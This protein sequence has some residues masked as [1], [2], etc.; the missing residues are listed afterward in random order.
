MPVRIKLK[1]F[2]EKAIG[3][4]YIP[5]TDANGDQRYLF[6]ADAIADD[7]DIELFPQYAGALTANDEIVL[8]RDATG[9]EVRVTIQQ[10]LDLVTLG[11]VDTI[12]NADGSIVGNRIVTGDT[13]SDLAFVDF[14]Q[15]LFDLNELVVTNVA[16]APAVDD[17]LV[18]EPGGTIRKRNIS[19]LPSGGGGAAGIFYALTPFAN[20][21]AVMVHASGTGVTAQRLSQSEIKFLVP[22]GVDLYGGAVRFTAIGNP[23]SDLYVQFDY[24]GNGADGNPRQVNINVVTMYPPDGFVINDVLLD[25]GG[26]TRALPLNYTKFSGGSE[27]ERYITGAPGA[28]GSGTPLE[29]LFRNYN[30]IANGGTDRTSFK[31]KF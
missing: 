8:Q 14:D 17:L 4:R 11:P 19:T 23:G 27:L 20:S 16:S 13:V 30:S 22:D 10:I 25:S 5:I 15:V 6:H 31:F 7:F 9:G 24:S 2:L 3:D 21:L 26:P 29:V 12:Y 18:I 28:A 1:N